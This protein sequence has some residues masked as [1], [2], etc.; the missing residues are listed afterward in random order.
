MFKKIYLE[1]TNKCNLS[2]SFCPMNKR[3]KCFMSL[4]DFKVILKKLKNHTKYL[5]FHVMGEPLIHPEINTF[6]DLASKDYYVNIT[7]NGYLI[8]NVS[9]NK[10]IRQLN[11]SLHSF[12]NRYNKSLEEYINDIFLTVDKLV[13][14]NTIINYRIWTDSEYKED[15]INLLEKK[16]NIK[17]NN[18]HTK[19]QDNVYIDFDDT[20]IWP[21][22]D[23]DFLLTSGSC[24]GTRS[25]IG[26]LVDGT[27]I[28]CCLDNNGYINLGN[29]YKQDLNDIISSDKF[30]EIKNGFLCNKKVNELCQRCNFYDGR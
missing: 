20:F 2:C 25:H 11:I 4:E 14:N 29:I 15:L 13:V 3:E 27:V 21:S 7:T 16:Y 30:L 10:N 28:P 18:E 19:L 23:N 9:D 24:M 8:K 22:L 26:I 6:I 5:Y 1:I 17:I 12:D